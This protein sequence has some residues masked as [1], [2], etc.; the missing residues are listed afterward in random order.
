MPAAE[1][2]DVELGVLV[3]LGVV[4]WVVVAEKRALIKLIINC[5]VVT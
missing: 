3:K 2:V 5:N 4:Q 1:M